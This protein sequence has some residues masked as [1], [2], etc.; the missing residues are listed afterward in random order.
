MITEPKIDP[1]TRKNSIEKTRK[2]QKIKKKFSFFFVFTCKNLIQAIFLK[3]HFHFPQ[4]LVLVEFPSLGNFRKS[5]SDTRASFCANP[6]RLPR[7]CTQL[8]L[9][10]TLETRFSIST[11]QAESAF[12]SLSS[13]SSML[14]FC[15]SVLLESTGSGWVRLFFC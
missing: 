13:L 14:F 15:W 2:P 9:T 8:E 1:Q 3:L 7:G 6:Q 4:N 5:N 10:E 12:F 11:L